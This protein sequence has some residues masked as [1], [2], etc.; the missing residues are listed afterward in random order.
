MAIHSALLQ[1]S[2]QTLPQIHPGTQ[3][4]R[5]QPGQAAAARWVP[6]SVVYMRGVLPIVPCPDPPVHPADGE[7]SYLD[8]EVQLKRERSGSGQG[9]DSFLE[10]WVVRLKDA[11]ARD[12]NILP[13]VIF[14]DK[15]S[16]P[17][18]G[19][20]AGY[21]CVGGQGR[22]LGV[23]AR[24]ERRWFHPIPLQDHGAVC[25]HRAGDWQVRARLL[26]RD[27]AFHHV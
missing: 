25:L 17:S 27:L 22:E 18:L 5:S 7:D 2:A 16:P 26:Q 24:G 13:M 11:P 3:R 6:L 20:L 19:F 9:S 1:A 15:V 14:N 23:V 21:G 12:G 8:V 4:P 10:W